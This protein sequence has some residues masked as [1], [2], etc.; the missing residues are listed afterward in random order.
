M[1]SAS[2]RLFV[3]IISMRLFA[4]DSAMTRRSLRGD[5]NGTKHANEEKSGCKHATQRDTSSTGDNAAGGTVA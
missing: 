4:G 2:C 5:T 1:M 3:S